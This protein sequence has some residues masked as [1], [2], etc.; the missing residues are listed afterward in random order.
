MHTVTT[1]YQPTEVLQIIR[2]NYIQQQ[3]F[4]DIVLKDQELTFE[5]TIS[6]WRDICDLVD[7]SELWKYLNYYFHLAA[8]QETW[9]TILEPDDEKALVDLCNFIANNAEKETIRPIKLFGNNCETAAIFKSLKIR[10][11]NRGIDV[12]DFRPSSQLEPLV[13]K[14]KSVLIEEIN[15]LAPTVLPPIDFKTNWVYKWG[16]RLLLTFLFVTFFLAWKESNWAWATGGI[17]LI[18][19]SMT[20]LGARLAPKQA[21]F[22]DI[23]TVADLVRKIDRKNLVLSNNNQLRSSAFRRNYR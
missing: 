13:K 8:D 4:D 2:A 10:L 21:S 5:T 23:Y 1:K 9:M 17:C 20:W 3:Q 14:Y 6:D 7:T 12:S 11:E 19:Y 18:G 22:K 15:Q 16:L